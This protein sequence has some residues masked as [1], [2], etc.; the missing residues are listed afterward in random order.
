[1][2]GPTTIE[3]PQLV[4]RAP[5]P[6]DVDPLYEIQGDA[7]VMR[8]TFVATDREATEQFLRSHAARFAED[9]F[10]PWTAVLKSERRV[11]GWGGLNKDPIAPEWGAEVAY[12]IHS[13]YH[14][15]GLASEIV[16]AALRLA[17]D[18]LALPEVYAFTR[19]ANVAS[20]RVLQKSGFHSVG[21][22]AELERDRYVIRRPAPR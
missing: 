18:E 15:R 7:S 4:L 2:S 5:E 12:F 16:S 10:A 3:T 11:V 9:G 14:G 21:Y 19:P 13:R 8:H 17:F 6:G 22:V 1:V 20:R